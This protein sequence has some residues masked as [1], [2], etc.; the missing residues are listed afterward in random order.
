[1][2][3]TLLG[4]SLLW[5]ALV[6]GNIARADNTAYAQDNT[7]LDD[8]D[9]SVEGDWARIRIRFSLP[10]NYLRHSP[11]ERGQL[12]QIFFNIAFLQAQNVS[13]Q[14]EVRNV[15]ATPVIPGTI[16]TYEPP[17]S[18]NLQR[19]PSSLKVQFDR[20][21]NYD[22]RMG[23]DRRSLIIYLPIVPAETKPNGTTKSKPE[24]TN[25]PEK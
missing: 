14:E 8:V 25:N 18:H 5:L 6:A 11:Q 23:D 17:L 21:V 22:V 4:I 2:K 16:I 1:M 13:L 19:E 7:I 20:V 24:K 3:K 9:T 12:L 15:R 10:V